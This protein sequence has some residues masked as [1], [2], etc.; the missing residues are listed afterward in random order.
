MTDWAYTE[1]GW[2]VDDVVISDDTGSLFFDDMESGPG[3]WVADGWVYGGLLDNDFEV[4]LI[5]PWQQGVNVG[6]DFEYMELDLNTEVGNSVLN[7]RFLG[8][9]V[10]TVVIRNRML[11]G[12][13]FPAGY[14]LDVIKGD[15]AP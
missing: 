12:F 14:F 11:E 6:T 4:T 2:Y 5:K 9:D 1:A 7:T 8:D 13:A 15:A 3:N 10:V